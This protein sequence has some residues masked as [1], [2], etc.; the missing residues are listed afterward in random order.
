MEKLRIWW[1][2]QIPLEAFK[3]EVKDLTEAKKILNVLTDYDEFQLEKNI[4][5]DYSNTGGVEFFD[6]QEWSEFEE[7]NETNIHN[8]RVR[9]QEEYNQEIDDIIDKLYYAYGSGTGV[10]FGIPSNLKSSVRA[11][12]KVIWEMK[13]KTQGKRETE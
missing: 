4:K 11:I 10:L 7:G 9:A 8:E 6:G 13:Q 3:V 2:P 5:P 12:V 1:I